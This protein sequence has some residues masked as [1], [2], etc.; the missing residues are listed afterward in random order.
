M[1]TADV[2]ETLPEQAMYRLV[3]L[4]PYANCVGIEPAMRPGA[5]AFN[6]WSNTFPAEELPSTGTATVGG[7]PFRFPRADGR[8]PDNVRC[9]GQVVALP[10]GRA[11]WLY[12]LAAAERR[13]EDHVTIS[14][15]DGGRRSQWLRVSDFW[16]ETAPR[17]GETLAFRTSVLL[18][19]NHADARMAPAIW[20][21]R[22][23]VTVPGDVTSVILPDNPAVHVFAITVLNEAGRTV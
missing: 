2:T 12:L 3:E 1:P 11:D 23:P 16:P 17:F 10:P 22:V 7:V 15:A 13:T 18:Y 20:R 4:T 6:I 8:R 19:P 21:Q 14:Y 9:R 5:G